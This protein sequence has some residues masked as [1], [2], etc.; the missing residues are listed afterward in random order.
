MFQRSFPSSPLHL[1]LAFFFFSSCLCSQICLS[2]A[3]GNVMTLILFNVVDQHLKNIILLNFS[4]S[5]C[6]PFYGYYISIILG[7]WMEVK[8]QKNKKS[9]RSAAQLMQ[10]PLADWKK[11]INNQ[12]LEGDLTSQFSATAINIVLTADRLL[13]ISDVSSQWLLFLSKCLISSHPKNPGLL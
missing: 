7:K 5:Y 6:E 11:T 8:W 3:R 4:S 2:L 10:S 9:L 13:Q 1:F 12:W